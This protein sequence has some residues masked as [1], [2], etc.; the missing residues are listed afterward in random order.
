MRFSGPTPDGDYRVKPIPNP[1]PPPGHVWVI[2]DYDASLTADPG[3]NVFTAEIEV[4]PVGGQHDEVTVH[5]YKL[6]ME[7]TNGCPS[8]VATTTQRH[9]SASG[10]AHGGDAELN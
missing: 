2:K 9:P 5:V 3:G 4:K 6:T 8:K 7:F 10:S 1:T